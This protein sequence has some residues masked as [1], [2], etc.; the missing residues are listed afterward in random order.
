MATLD[1]NLTKDTNGASQTI[2]SRN[3]VM[4]DKGDHRE[5]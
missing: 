3:P 5:L 4:M 2:P 1:G